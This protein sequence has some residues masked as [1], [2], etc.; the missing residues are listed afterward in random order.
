MDDIADI[1]P[2]AGDVASDV[3]YAEIKRLMTPDEYE[4]FVRENK[5]LPSILAALKGVAEEKQ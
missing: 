3:A 4:R 5:W 1:I 2:F